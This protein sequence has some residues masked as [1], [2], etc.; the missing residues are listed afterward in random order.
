MSVPES[1]CPK[2]ILF[3]PMAPF[4]AARD[5]ATTGSLS[6]QPH[7]GRNSLRAMSDLKPPP[8]DVAA[9][10]P[11]A[12]SLVE[13]SMIVALTFDD[14]FRA[15]IRGHTVIDDLISAAIARTF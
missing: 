14:D 6:S 3:W 13:A 2:S 8:G 4:T 7:G 9:S 15:A 5:A 11:A 1:P 10:S 12:S